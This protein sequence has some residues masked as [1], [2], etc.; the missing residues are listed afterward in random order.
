MRFIVAVDGSTESERA[1][2]YAV[3]IADGLDASVDIVHSIT[4]EIYSDDGR[5]LIE[6]MSDAEERSD[7]VLDEAEEIARSE[8]FDEM[9]TESLYGEP[10]EEIVKYADE[11]G[12]DGIFVGHRGVSQEYED[13]VG[14]VAQELVRRANVPVTVVR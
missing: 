7:S 12:A 4:P 3:D 8:D 5:V 1:I 13:V 6:D 9:R 14:S 10:A 2:R 11:M